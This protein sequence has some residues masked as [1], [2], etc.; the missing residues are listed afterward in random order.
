MKALS[1]AVEGK[2]P[3]QRNAFEQGAEKAPHLLGTAL[4]AFRV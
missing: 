1:G 3:R 2:G 4:L